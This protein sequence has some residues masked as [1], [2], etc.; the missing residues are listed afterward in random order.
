ML[1]HLLLAR[2]SFNNTPIKHILHASHRTND[3]SCLSSMVF[4]CTLYGCLVYEVTRGVPFLINLCKWN[5][6]RTHH[7]GCY[8]NLRPVYLFIRRFI[9]L[10]NRYTTYAGFGVVKR[11]YKCL[12]LS[13]KDSSVTSWECSY[14]WEF[15]IVM[16]EWFF[17]LGVE[18]VVKYE[19]K[20]R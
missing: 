18:K 12:L 4:R 6:K 2:R 14:F 3:I 10:G 20:I 1:A 16:G 13:M 5:N 7:T 9:T 11:R 19:E 17:L 8:V 15:H